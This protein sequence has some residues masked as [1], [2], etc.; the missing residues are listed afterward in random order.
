MLNESVA[1]VADVVVSFN[2]D[3]IIFVFGVNSIGNENVALENSDVAMFLDKVKLP[4]ER[5]EKE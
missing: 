4:P 3:E 5:E 2:I 1:N